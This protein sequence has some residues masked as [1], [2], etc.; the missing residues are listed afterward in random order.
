MQSEFPDVFE[1]FTQ[2]AKTT[3]EYGGQLALQMGAAYVGTEHLLLGILK[4]NTS[5]GARLLSESG[6]TLE[7]INP[8][9]VTP[10]ANIDNKPFSPHSI[11]LSETAKKTITLAL[12]V[13]QEYGQP[14]A[15][16]EHLLFAI[17]NQKNSRAQTILAELK[18]DPSKLRTDIETFLQNQPQ[19]FDQPM[20]PGGSNKR[21][22][23][24]KLR[25][26]S[27]LV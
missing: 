14:Y 17:L 3:L 22:M 7:K 26:L 23:V 27:T 15:G 12:R 5:L 24:A 18:V 16:T 13:A 9:L 6:V 8:S 25:L 11:D 4:S 19:S 21:E 20:Q 1:R 2:N 10:A